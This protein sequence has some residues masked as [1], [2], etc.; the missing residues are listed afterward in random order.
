MSNISRLGPL[1]GFVSG[2]RDALTDLDLLKPLVNNLGMLANIH[3]LDTADHRSTVFKR[4]RTSV[5]LVEMAD[6]VRT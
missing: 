1:Q 6:A 5:V 4:T 2:T 3:L